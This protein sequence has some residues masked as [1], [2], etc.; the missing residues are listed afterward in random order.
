MSS[1]EPIK[2]LSELFLTSLDRHPRPNAFL[3]KRDGAYKPVSSDETLG[4]VA[5]L[6]QGL[7]N[8]A[9]G[10][11]DRLAILS[12]NRLEWALTDYAAL[13]LGAISVPIYPTLLEDDLEYILRDSGA[14]GIVLSTAD[15]LRKI[16][17]ISSQLPDLRFVLAMDPVNAPSS[18]G[19]QQWW[20]VVRRVPREPAVAK[21]RDSARKAKPQDVATILY[22]SGTTGNPKGVILTHGTAGHGDVVPASVAHF[23]ADARFRL[24]L[25]R[26]LHCICREL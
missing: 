1:S 19:A 18:A 20:D 23:P 24:F 9:L 13:A 4:T 22:T 2:T 3:A 17:N 8:L 11:G 25:L 26:R 14:K 16:C 12:D 10:A 7:E 5:A 21:F 15:Q 6:A